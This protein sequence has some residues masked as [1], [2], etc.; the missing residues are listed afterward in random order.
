MI[1]N[2]P[3]GYDDTSSAHWAVGRGEDRVLIQINDGEEEARI[4]LTPEEAREIARD[5]CGQ[6]ESV[7]RNVRWPDTM[8]SCPK[9]DHQGLKKVEP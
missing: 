6:A 1:H 5:L 7:E 9:M 3:S 8:D 2:K 4:H